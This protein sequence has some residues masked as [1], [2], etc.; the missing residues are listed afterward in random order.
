MRKPRLSSEHSPKDNGVT[1]ES[2]KLPSPSEDQ[3][4]AEMLALSG[5]AEVVEI[6]SLVFREAR[7]HSMSESHI[8]EIIQQRYPAKTEAQIGGLLQEVVRAMDRWIDRVDGHEFL[9][10]AELLDRSPEE[11]ALDR[12]AWDRLANAT[13]AQFKIL[14]GYTDRRRSGAKPPWWPARD[15]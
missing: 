4:V 14:S 3:I 12:A 13:E 10:F 6:C 15:H 1:L 7:L 8:L 9:T 11:R 5:L 2:Q